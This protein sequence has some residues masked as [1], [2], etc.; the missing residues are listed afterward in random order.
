MTT[1]PGVTGKKPLLTRKQLGE[2][3]RACGF[4]IGDSTLVK[5][6]SPGINEGP[7]VAAYWGKRPLY[8]PDVGVEW[9]EG[10]LRRAQVAP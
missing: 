9:A 6:C 1:A 5:I 3:L 8:D 4:P 10:R 2:H 7:A